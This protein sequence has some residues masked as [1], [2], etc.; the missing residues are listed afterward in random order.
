MAVD[1]KT[2]NRAIENYVAD[3]RR[4]MN[5]DKAY[6]YG[7]YAKGTYS[8][9]SDVDIC[10]FSSDF[11]G[12]REVDVLTK[13]LGLARSYRGIGIE[14]QAFPTSEIDRGNP[15]VREVIRTGREIPASA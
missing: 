5:I 13:L 8:E 6:L 12:Q 14:P 10:F 2:V 11:E 9:Y 15:F 7:S 3:V 4:E 1:I